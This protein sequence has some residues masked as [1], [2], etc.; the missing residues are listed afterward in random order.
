MVK[1][2]ENYDLTD[3]NTFGIET[4]AKLFT[5]I[6]NYEEFLSILEHNSFQEN[7][8]MVLGGG[9]NIIFANEIFDGLVLYNQVK[10]IKVLKEDEKAIILEIGGGENWH[11]LVLFSLE[12]GWRGLENL[13]LIPGSV[14][15]AP[16]QNIGAYGVELK[17]IFFG[18]EAWHFPSGERHM[19]YEGACNFGY[20]NSAFKQNLKGQYFIA[21]VQLILDQTK[22]FSIDYGAIK[23]ELAQ[24]NQPDFTAKDI[25]NAI[26]KIRNS[27]L[28]NPKEVGNVGSFFKNPVIELDNFLALKEKFP[29]LKFYEIENKQYKIPAAWL[30]ENCGLKGKKDKNVGVSPNHALVLINIGKA[31][32]KE[33][34]ELSNFVIES[35]N[36]KFGI[37]LEPEANIIY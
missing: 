7:K 6:S 2:F 14:G 19:I 8:K 35:V 15:A 29:D 28:P 37:I 4:K 24:L 34:V 23:T 16:I 3:F 20:R 27:K 30:I 11:D 21:K 22:D 12:N 1:I 13:S 9:S 32:G 18:I 10:G 25:S 33:V 5:S 31:T 36:N 26:I 17:D